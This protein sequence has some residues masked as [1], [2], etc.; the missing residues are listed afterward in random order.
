MSL[1]NIVQR[2]TLYNINIRYK[3][4]VIISHCQNDFRTTMVLEDE[5]ARYP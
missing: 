3:C 4:S 2:E 5:Y 1:E